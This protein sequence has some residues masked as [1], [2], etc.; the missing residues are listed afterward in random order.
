MPQALARLALVLAVVTVPAF[1][2]GNKE[3]GR[4]KSYTCTGCHGIPGYKNVYPHYHVPKIFGQNEAYL[5]AALNGYK[6][7]ERTH[8]TMNAQGQS[9]SEQD[10]ADIAAFLSDK[11]EA[12]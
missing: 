9:L 10:I 5:I 11:S 2:A 4:I 6:A 8:P 3:D 12:K 7:G 1:A